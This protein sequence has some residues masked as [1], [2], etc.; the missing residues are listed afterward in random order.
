MKFLNK[1]IILFGTIVLAVSLLFHVSLYTLIQ[2]QAYVW[3]L[4]PGIL[5]PLILFLSGLL[6]GR[7]DSNDNYMGF[8]YHLI[9]YLGCNAAI[10]LLCLPGYVSYNYLKTTLVSNLVWGALLIVHLLVFLFFSFSKAK[11]AGN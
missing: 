1:H 8:N 3:I 4:V 9:T 2:Q 7:Q 11:S 5:Y 6:I 10:V